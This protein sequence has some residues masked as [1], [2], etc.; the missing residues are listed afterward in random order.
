VSTING[1]ASTGYP[2]LIVVPVVA[3]QW[4]DTKK[5]S[6]LSPGVFA[7]QVEGARF[8]KK[9]YRLRDRPLTPPGRRRNSNFDNVV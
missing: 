7:G 6:I 8:L 2:F 5:G 4:V 9:F 1:L 3:E